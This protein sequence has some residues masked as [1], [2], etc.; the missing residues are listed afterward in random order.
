MTAP[1]GGL[2]LELDRRINCA[3]QQNDVPVVKTIRLT[4][5]ASEAMRDLQVRVAAEPDF[6]R[7]SQESHLTPACATRYATLT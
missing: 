6:C 4:N 7:P 5:L 3:L 1:T 2:H